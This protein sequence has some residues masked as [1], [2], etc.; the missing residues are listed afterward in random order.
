M[1]THLCPECGLVLDQN[2][3]AAL[4]ILLA[5]LEDLAALNRTVGQAEM[6]RSQERRNASGQKTTSLRKQLCPVTSAG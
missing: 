2:W 3:N 5:A 6:G 1:R 4:N